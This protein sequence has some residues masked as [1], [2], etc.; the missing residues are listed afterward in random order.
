MVGLTIEGE[1][2]LMRLSIFWV[3]ESSWLVRQMRSCSSLS[4]DEDG[5]ESGMVT[6]RAPR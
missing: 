1:T 6:T 5:A 4:E 2:W 3:R